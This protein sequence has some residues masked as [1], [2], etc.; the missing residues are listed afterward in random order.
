MHEDSAAK[1]DLDASESGHAIP[2]HCTGY[3]ATFAMGLLTFPDGMGGGQVA[4]RSC[5]C[6]W[7]SYSKSSNAPSRVGW[8]K[9]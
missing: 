9:R 8:R 1:Y 6:R 5:Y 4:R 2:M 7:L 3:A